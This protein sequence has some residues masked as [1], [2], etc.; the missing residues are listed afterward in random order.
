MTTPFTLRPLGV[1]LCLG[2]LLALV[3]SGCTGEGEKTAADFGIDRIAAETDYNH[4]G[5]DDY[6][7]FLGGARRDAENHPRYD[8]AYVA[9]GYPAE[10][11][12]VCA[13]VVWRAFREAG[14]SLKDMVDADIA[15][16]PTHYPRASQPDPNI[17]FRRVKNL[18]A[19]FVKYGQELTLDVN[20]I[21]QW[22]PGDIVIFENP[23]H[24]GVVSDRRDED[25]VVYLIHNAGQANREENFL[26]GRLA[27]LLGHRPIGHYRF[28]ATKVDPDVLRPWI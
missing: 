4:N 6:T 16:D 24:I 9:G 11:V 15:V 13:D 23:D 26:G 3:L 25:G 18:H 27:R 1:F 7:D 14:Y 12:G 5:R 21:D 2:S 8:G 10:D 17:D 28:D 19:F 20:E 22:M